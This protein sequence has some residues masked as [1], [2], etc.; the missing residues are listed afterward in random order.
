MNNNQARRKILLDV[1][2]QRTVMWGGHPVSK[3]RSP[4]LVQSPELKHLR[5]SGAVQ[6]KLL[7]QRT[8]GANNWITVAHYY[9]PDAELDTSYLHRVKC[10]LCENELDHWT[11]MCGGRHKESCTLRVET[12]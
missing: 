7:P 8:W 9:V 4:L 2:R 3:D 1:I 6:R 11:D 10:P 5:E 12:L